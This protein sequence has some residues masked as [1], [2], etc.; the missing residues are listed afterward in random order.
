[1]NDFFMEINTEELVLR[2]LEGWNQLEEK[3]AFI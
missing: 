2:V 1:M 3:Y